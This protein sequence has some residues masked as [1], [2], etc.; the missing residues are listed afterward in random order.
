M[1]DNANGSRLRP[2]FFG[3]H[4]E[5]LEATGKNLYHSSSHK[6]ATEKVCE[7]MASHL[8]LCKFRPHL[9]NPGSAPVCGK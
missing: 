8:P 3:L 4:L 2:S 6:Y 7:E 9:L 1:G 5:K